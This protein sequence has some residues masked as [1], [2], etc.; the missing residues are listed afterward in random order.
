M[1]L[2]AFLLP[3]SVIAEPLPELEQLNAGVYGEELTIREY[4]DFMADTYGVS[5]HEMKVTINCESGWNPGAIN[6]QE[7]HSDGYH[8]SYG[9]AQYHPK[10]FASFAESAGI[11]NPD[12]NNPFHQIEAMAWGFAN[13]KQ[14]HWTCWRNNFDI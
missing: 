2:A 8:S 7:Q 6:D 11:Q 13:G 1:I 3:L 14:R 5:A 10:T 4:V 9:I 12:I